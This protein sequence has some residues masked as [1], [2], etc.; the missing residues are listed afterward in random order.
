M[1]KIKSFLG[2]FLIVSLIVVFNSCSKDSD[3]TIENT[4]KQNILIFKTFEEYKTVLDEVG[5]LKENERIAWE[6]TK[7]FKSFGS[8]CDDFFY[9]VNFD[10]IKSLEVLEALDPEKKFLKI[11][12]EAGELIIEPQELNSHE[13][14][15]VNEDKM[16]IAESKTFK[17]LESKLVSTDIKYFEDL[18]NLKSIEEALLNTK[19]TVISNVLPK[20][21]SVM[22]EDHTFEASNADYKI[23]VWI[24]TENYWNFTSDFDTYRQVEFTIHNYKYGILGWYSKKLETD[25][26][27][28]LITFDDNAPDVYL[29][30]HSSSTNHDFSSYGKGY[31]TFVESG[32]T[33]RFDP[34]FSSYYIYAGNGHV[35]VSGSK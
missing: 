11:F 2:C 25:Y 34:I 10:T 17:L 12:K 5:N 3:L 15:I 24:Q 1:K 23:K 32:W 28:D 13:R 19:F 30:L 14:Y 6:K 8:I 4:Q 7:G 20:E 27:I 9:S 21:K 18:K 33:N 22:I 26:T 31:E 29:E 16:F 35:S